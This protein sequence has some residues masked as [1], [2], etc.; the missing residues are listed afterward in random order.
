MDVAVDIVVEVCVAVAVALCLILS[1][2]LPEGG[3]ERER[4]VLMERL[5]SVQGQRGE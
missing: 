5:A 2:R 1:L 4:G 3:E